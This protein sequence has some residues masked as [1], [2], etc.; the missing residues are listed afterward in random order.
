[1]C[2]LRFVYPFLDAH[3]PYAW[4]SYLGLY[5]VHWGAFLAFMGLVRAKGW[6]VRKLHDG[7]LPGLRRAERAER[8]GAFLKSAEAQLEGKL[9][10]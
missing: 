8:E 7:N 6:A 2:G 3:K 1:M 5:A 4:L 10:R 9:V